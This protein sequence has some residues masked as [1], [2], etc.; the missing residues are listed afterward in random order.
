MCLLCLYPDGLP[1]RPVLSQLLSVR[2]CL[3]LQDPGLASH[4]VHA[5]FLSFVRLYHGDPAALLAPA[6][7]R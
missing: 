2:P 3:A 7:R 5:S 4:Y 6:Q 1:C